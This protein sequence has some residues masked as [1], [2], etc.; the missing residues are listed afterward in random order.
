M[1]LKSN[2]SIDKISIGNQKTNKLDKP[3]LI[4]SVNDID[5]KKIPFSEIDKTY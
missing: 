5:L 2:L 1:R 3:V 4:A